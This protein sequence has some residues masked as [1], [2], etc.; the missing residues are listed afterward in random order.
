LRLW[1]SPFG[2][3]GALRV[4]VRAEKLT[5]ERRRIAIDDYAEKVRASLHLQSF[6][7]RVRVRPRRS[8]ACET[9]SKWNASRRKKAIARISSGFGWFLQ[10]QTDHQ[11]RHLCGIAG[12]GDID[13]AFARRVMASTATVNAADG[14]P[15][16][17]CGRLD[18]PTSHVASKTGRCSGEAIASSA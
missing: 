8:R 1:E 18:R 12:N 6:L 3:D 2:T 5:G 4:D 7:I 13:G 10:K 11:E 14:D 16:Q 15:T 9:L 17:K